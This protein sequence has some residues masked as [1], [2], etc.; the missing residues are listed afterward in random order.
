M[1][2]DT[3]TI[4]DLIGLQYEDCS[5][6]VRV[7]PNTSTDRVTVH[8]VFVNTNAGIATFGGISLV[9]LAGLRR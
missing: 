8:L 4:L 6:Q 3:G 9:V 5:E 7:N 1:W 2:T